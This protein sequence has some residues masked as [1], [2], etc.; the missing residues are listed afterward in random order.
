MNVKEIVPNTNATLLHYFETAL[1]FTLLSVWIITAFQSRYR[2]RSGVTFW[3]R[4]GWP[5]FFFLRMFG[6]DPYA[7]TSKDSLQHDLD[8]MLT[9]QGILRDP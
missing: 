7:P 6:K 3:Q 9:D 8:L 2:F 4:L 5:L 1:A